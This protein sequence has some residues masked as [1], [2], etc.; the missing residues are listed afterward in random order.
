MTKVLSQHPSKTAIG[1]LRER[2][3]NGWS[4]HYGEESPLFHAAASAAAR[5]VHVE[6]E[7]ARTPPKKT[8]EKKRKR[9]E[10]TAQQRTTIGKH[11]VVKYYSDT[12][13]DSDWVPSEDDY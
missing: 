10:G 6:L 8:F 9:K 2:L 3:S 4:L 11:K 7:S 13:T 12:D 1:I 5:R